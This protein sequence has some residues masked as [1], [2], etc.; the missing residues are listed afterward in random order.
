MKND[1]NLNIN[2]VIHY[3][4]VLFTTTCCI[5]GLLYITRGNEVTSI[6]FAIL[7]A[8]G[9]ISLVEFM[10]VFKAKENRRNT[11]IPELILILLYVVL[12]VVSTPVI[13]HFINTEFA[14]KN[15]IKDVGNMKLTAMEQMVIAF[16]NQVQADTALMATTM[17]SDFTAYFNMGSSNLTNRG[18]LETKLKAPP[19]NIEFSGTSLGDGV[20][21]KRLYKQ[22]AQSVGSNYQR[23]TSNLPAIKRSN[24]AFIPNAKWVI[25]DWVRRKLN[26]V[27]Y[28]IDDKLLD[29]ITQ[30]QTLK[31]DFEFSMPE[32]TSLPLDKPITL[33]KDYKPNLLVALSLLLLC[34]LLM[35]W[36]YLFYQ[37]SGGTR[38]Y[39]NK[40]QPT[41]GIEF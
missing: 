12:T 21:K 24:D 33:I 2:M 40:A 25:N 28:E 32:E 38:E 15:K 26:R 5:F 29:N 10:V 13:L 19:Y 37:R 18:S 1:K 16:E 35:L 17:K 27:Y 6:I 39:K 11:S 34:H 7:M 30:L 9:F 8:V 20:L 22:I 41:T 14:L 3:L 36:P 31:P 23:L 4:G